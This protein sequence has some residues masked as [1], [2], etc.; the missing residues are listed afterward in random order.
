MIPEGEVSP[1]PIHPHSPIRR[2]HS[3]FHYPTHDD[4]VKVSD[5]MTR[6]LRNDLST[7]TSS[8]N[9]NLPALSLERPS[10]SG[11]VRSNSTKAINGS[12]QRQNSM[13]L[14]NSNKDSKKGYL[15]LKCE[16]LEVDTDHIRGLMSTN[17]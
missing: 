1:L 15:T 6:A 11:M 10:R 7:T 8:S 2:Q 17:G 12:F 13:N 14:G 9:K 5:E 4:I 3:T 16:S